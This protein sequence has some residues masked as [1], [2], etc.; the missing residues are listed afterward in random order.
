MRLRSSVRGAIRQD[1]GSVS[2]GRDSDRDPDRHPA[3]SII[4]FASV[5]S[6]IHLDNNFGDGSNSRMFKCG[7]KRCLFQNKFSPQDRFVSTTTGRIYNCIIPPGTTYIND[8]SPNVIYLI[9]CDRCKL[10]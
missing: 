1:V 10:Q 2:L 4:L 6:N 3:N 8:H 9:T 7:S 5:L